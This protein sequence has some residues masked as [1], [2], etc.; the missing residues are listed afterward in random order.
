MRDRIPQDPAPPDG[1]VFPSASPAYSAPRSVS[2]L[3]GRT[4]TG[5]ENGPGTV[6]ANARTAKV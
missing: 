6:P 1:L 3:C 2:Y 4:F 5:R